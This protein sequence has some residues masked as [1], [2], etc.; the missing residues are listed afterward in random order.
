[1]NIINDNNNKL[2]NV[3]NYVPLLLS[4]HITVEGAVLFTAIERLGFGNE[5]LSITHDDKQLYFGIPFISWGQLTILLNMYM[6]PI[7]TIDNIQIG[8]ENMDD[9]FN[10]QIEF[11]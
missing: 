8:L 1:M 5:T 3:T 11:S 10:V 2:Y 4:D 9:M 7:S 6:K